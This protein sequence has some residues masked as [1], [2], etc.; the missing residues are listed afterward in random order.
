MLSSLIR[1]R[2]ADPAVLA[3]IKN[4]NDDIRLLASEERLLRQELGL[5]PVT[6][7]DDPRWT[8]EA[9]AFERKT[10]SRPH[11]KRGHFA[12]LPLRRR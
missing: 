2:H 5:P 12:I 10:L 7:A 1:R 8:L 3:V 6:H 4:I 11:R 9:P